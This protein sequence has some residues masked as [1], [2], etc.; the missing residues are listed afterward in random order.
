[1]PQRWR[2]VIGSDEA[3]LAYKDA[4]KADLKA[5]QGVADVYDLGVQHDQQA[6]FIDVPTAAAITVTEGRADRA[7]L[8]CGSGL[9]AALGANKVSGIRA[10][11]AFD[12]PSVERSVLDNDAQVLCFGHQIISLPM[13]RRLAREWLD[14][15]FDNRA[16]HN[17]TLF[18]RRENKPIQWSRQAILNPTKRRAFNAE[19]EQQLGQYGIVRDIQSLRAVVFDLG[20]ASA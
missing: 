12:S 13:A 3:G 6:K 15:R 10:V 5:E 18:A 9:S 4:L 7:L 19:S 17:V 16:A 2:I 20:G 8:I 11:T 1:M 14:Y